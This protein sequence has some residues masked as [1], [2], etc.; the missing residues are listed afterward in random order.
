[1]VVLLRIRRL[2]LVLIMHPSDDL[3]TD[4]PRPPLFGVESFID[5]FFAVKLWIAPAASENN[6]SHQIEIEAHPGQG[7]CRSSMCFE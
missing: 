7:L 3:D 2:S 6:G 5:R 1:M 4:A